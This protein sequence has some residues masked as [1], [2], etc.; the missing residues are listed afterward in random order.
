V[1]HKFITF[2]LAVK[3]NQLPGPGPV[4]CHSALRPRKASPDRERSFQISFRGSE[5]FARTQWSAERYDSSVINHRRRPLA[6]A[7]TCPANSLRFFD[8]DGILARPNRGLTS[9]EKKRFSEENEISESIR[10]IIYG[11]D[12]DCKQ[13]KRYCTRRVSSHPSLPSRVKGEIALSDRREQTGERPFDFQ[14]RR[15]SVVRMEIQF[16]LPSMISSRSRP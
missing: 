5:L 8:A 1:R 4:A 6:S 12:A 11:R 9:G 16:H 3:A 15:D 10:L 14:R 2:K 13:E 7:K